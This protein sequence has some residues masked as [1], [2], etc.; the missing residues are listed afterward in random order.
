MKCDF[1]LD[2][3][4]CLCHIWVHSRQPSGHNP[5]PNNSLEPIMKTTLDV[6]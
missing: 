6:G 1:L 5:L 3:A 2:T 4:R